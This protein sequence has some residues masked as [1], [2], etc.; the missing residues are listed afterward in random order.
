MPTGLPSVK[1]AQKEAQGKHK[2]WGEDAASFGKGS[3]L[4]YIYVQDL[5]M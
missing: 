2:S 4:T 1:E 3:K 5:N